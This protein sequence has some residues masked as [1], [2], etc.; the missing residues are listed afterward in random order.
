MNLKQFDAHLKKVKTAIKGLTR[1]IKKEKPRHDLEYHFCNRR[2]SNSAYSDDLLDIEQIKNILTIKG[3]VGG[4]LEVILKLEGK[5]ESILDIN[6][7]DTNWI[8][9]YNDELK[10]I[11]G[12]LLK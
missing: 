2:M 3:Y 5:T 7:Y 11:Y 6:L 10:I 1:K 9:D 12:G 8:D 4:Y